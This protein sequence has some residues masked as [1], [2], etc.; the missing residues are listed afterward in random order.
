ME[1]NSVT[2]IAILCVLLNSVVLCPNI[3]AGA[4]E[5]QPN[6]SP[7]I[8]FPILSPKYSSGYGQRNHPVFQ[9]SQ[10]HN[11]IDIAVPEYSH[12]RAAYE[13]IVVYAE[14]FQGYGKL[15][16]IQHPQGFASLY[17]HLSEVRVNVGQKVRTG[18]I[19][20]RVGSTGVSTGSHLHFEW[21][22]DGKAL[23]P[24]SEFPALFKKAEG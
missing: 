18:E 11:G 3:W 7:S 15:V 9:R 5:Q 23:D 1:R 6:K 8:V 21:R 14:R 17:G 13:G 12:V 10:H 20:G 16:T 24:L 22:K 2:L 19:I 4:P